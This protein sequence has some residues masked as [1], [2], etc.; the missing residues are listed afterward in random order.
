[1]AHARDGHSNNDETSEFGIGLKAAAINM[2]E[3]ISIYTYSFS[4]KQ[5]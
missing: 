1:M 2:G 4:E 5:I 3:K